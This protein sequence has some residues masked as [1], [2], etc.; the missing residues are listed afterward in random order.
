[1]DG[2]L[3]KDDYE[4]LRCLLNMHPKVTPIPVGRI[5]DKLDSY[6][7]KNDYDA[8]ERHLR[9]WLAEAEELYNK[10]IGAENG[11]LSLEQWLRLPD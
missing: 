4:E 9:Y 6:L 11:E 10:A 7:N 1:M 3:S 5:I 2:I 8:A